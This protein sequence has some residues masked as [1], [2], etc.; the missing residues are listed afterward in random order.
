MTEGRVAGMGPRVYSFMGHIDGRHL[1]TLM[2]R[3]APAVAERL[4]DDGVHAVFLTPA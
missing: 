3:T 4:R 1:A 2:D